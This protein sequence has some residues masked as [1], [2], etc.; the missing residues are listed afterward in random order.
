MG[1]SGVITILIAVMAYQRRKDI[2]ITRLDWTFL[3]LAISSLPA[4]AL[5][6]DPLWAVIILTAVDVLGFGPSIR[7]AYHYPFEEDVTFF[8]LFVIRNVLSVIALEHYSMTTMLFPLTGSAACII[9][10][11]TILWRRKAL[12]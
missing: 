1:V 11:L 4:W 10:I 3:I 2:V 7:K 5:T 8:V 6:S 12:S 9:L